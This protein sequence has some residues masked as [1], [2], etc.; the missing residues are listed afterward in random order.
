MKVVHRT[1]PVYFTIYGIHSYASIP[2]QNKNLLFFMSL[3]SMAG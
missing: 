2:V 1:H 3:G